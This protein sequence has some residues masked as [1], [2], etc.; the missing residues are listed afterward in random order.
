MPTIETTNTV[1]TQKVDTPVI[2]EEVNKQFQDLAVKADAADTPKTLN[3]FDPALVDQG[4]INAIPKAKPR[5]TFDPR[6]ENFFNEYRESFQRIEPVQ[7][8]LVKNPEKDSI[9]FWKT[10]EDMALSSAQGI[11]K[12]AYNQLTF[13]TDTVLPNSALNVFGGAKTKF[14][15]EEVLS[16]KDFIPK[17]VNEDDFK[18]INSSENSKA[19]VF[20]NPKT[21]AGN[22][23]ES[24]SQFITGFYGPNKVLKMFGVGGT[25]G[26][27]SLR[28]VTA[29]AITDATVWDPNQER[30]SNWLTTSNSPLLNNVVTNYL[31]SNPEDTEW[32]GRL[33]NV[34][35]GMLTGTVIGAGF[36]G[37]AFGV[38]GAGKFA[39]LIGIKSVKKANGIADVT[40]KQ[41]VYNEAGKA[42]KEIEKGNLD[43]PIV[44][45]QIAD[46]N[47]AINLNKLEEIIRIG[48]TT[49]KENSESFIKSILNTK[50][51]NSSE[52][53]LHTLDTVSDLFTAEQRAFLKN[54]VLTNKTAEELAYLLARDKEEILKILPQVA[55]TLEQQTVRMLASKVILQDLAENMIE[56]SQNYVQKFGK[57][58][59]LW[60]KEAQQEILKYGDIIRKT[61]VNTKEIIR[62]SAR[63]VQA[64]R[65]KVSKSGTR[66]DAEE[67]ANIIK[68][69]EGD[70]ITIANKIVKA[71]PEEVLNIVAKTKFH[72]AIEVYNTAMVNSLLSGTGTQKVQ[73]LSNLS[74][75]IIR[76][77]DMIQGGIVRRDHRTIRLGFAQY[78]G[79]LYNFK[80]TWRATWLSLK[81]SDP[82]LD[83]KNRTLDSLEIVNGKAVKTISGANLGFNGKI[84]TAIDWIGNAIDIPSRLMV[85]SDELFKQMNYRG[86]IY[87]NAVN[88]TM[89]R[90]LNIYS[91]EGKANIKKIMDEAFDLD[92]RANV[93][94]NP[95]AA[96]A[97]KYAQESTLTNDIRGGSYGDWGSSIQKFLYAHPSL[98]FMAPFV[99]TPTNIWRHV[100]NR[101]PVWGIYT[102]Q[103]R[104][105]WNSGDPRARAEVIG[106]QMFGVSSALLAL[107][108]AMSSI[109]TK[110]GKTLP[111]LT[112]NG[113]AN[114]DVKK[115][116]MEYGWQPYSIGMVNKDGSV[117][118]VQ[119]NR[120]DPRFYIFGL[121]ADI[122]ENINN[123][124][125]YDKEAATLGIILSIYKNTLGKAY[126]KGIADTFETLANPTDNTIQSLFGKIVGNA[127][128]FGAFRGEFEKT[129]YETR[130]FLDAVIQRSSLGSRFLDPKR[131]I[132]T[133]DPIRKINA[134]LTWNPDGIISVSG[135]TMGPALVGKSIDVKDDPIR[136]ELFRLKV[137]FRQPSIKKSDVDLTE[138]KQ[139]KQSAYDYW[140]ERI[141]KTKN[142]SGRTLKD[143]LEQEINSSGYKRLQEGEDGNI[144]G[145]ELALKVIYD[146]YK[147]IA[148][149]DMLRKYPEVQKAIDSKVTTKIDLLGAK[150]EEVKQK[151]LNK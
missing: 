37:V 33:K 141:G 10:L 86:R 58:R 110:D 87:A 26:L 52:Y 123:I 80:D 56:A 77:L 122:K 97:L 59:N 72:K 132:L 20:Y 8:G 29:G 6:I 78:Q 129:S 40:E 142:T 74:E 27:W 81:Q 36:K 133:G 112:G 143:R 21:L 128:P 18:E 51:F 117:T 127:I 50:S 93:K 88:N 100:E 91:K 105:M 131:D 41:K 146:E 48:E 151:K 120:M 5:H 90:E 114:L 39:T 124:N 67:F 70:A 104:E 106:R 32:E 57:D 63:T 79:L 83:P 4:A 3:Q 1:S 44:K 116:W 94:N 12:G 46:G 82:V 25:F 49:A 126:M 19:P 16:F 9:G 62:N 109:Q 54:D 7:S 75:M 34:L 64:G 84:G 2:S 98:R 38:A 140:I 68:E 35:E 45:K 138:I 53:V 76:P 13:L 30:L 115:R 139:G 103:M 22:L 23:T 149:Q 102:K 137:P 107:N 95:T 89:E 130:S 135:V 69:Y 92:G 42:L 147:D 65:I 43:A 96:D 14:S 111:L 47:P 28:G 136:Y 118:Y 60:T 144:G 150:R 101:I 125:D 15:E 71:K 73:I 55:A 31:A 61:V 113:P 11:T 108:Y 85:A 99:K 134:G 145:K 17:F 121:A 148:Y 119:Y 66:F 24:M